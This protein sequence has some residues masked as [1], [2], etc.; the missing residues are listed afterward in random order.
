M[1]EPNHKMV[2]Q[3]HVRFFG[4][5]NLLAV[6]ALDPVEPTIL[7]SQFVGGLRCELLKYRSDLLCEFRTVDDEAELGV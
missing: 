2:A 6:M 4:M 7:Q 1:G 5:D 3:G